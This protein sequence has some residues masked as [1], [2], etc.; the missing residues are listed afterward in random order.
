VAELPE[1]FGIEVGG[2]AAYQT[3]FIEEGSTATSALSAFREAGGAIRTQD[4]YR[5]WGET[6]DALA[7]RAENTA[8]DFTQ[9]PRDE[10]LSTW[11]GVR[12]GS[13]AYSIDIQVRATEELEPGVR[14][15][16]TYFTPHLLYTDQ[17]IDY[18]T[19]VSMAIGEY[20]DA[21]DAGFDS[22]VGTVLGGMVR[23]VYRPGE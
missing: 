9:L 21:Q 12:P 23:N 17:L 6:V 3:R 19:A 5:A 4:W 15:T 11:G 18:D 7:L 1:E 16:E 8:L 20:I 14:T 22:A 13:Y 10:Q 2:L